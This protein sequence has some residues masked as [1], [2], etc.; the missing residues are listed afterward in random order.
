MSFFFVVMSALVVFELSYLHIILCCILNVCSLW[1]MILTV[2]CI[3]SIKNGVCM[4]VNVCVGGGYMVAHI[5]ICNFD[6]TFATAILHVHA[7]CIQLIISNDIH[8]GHCY[9]AGF[10]L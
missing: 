5:Y 6:H 2:C 7:M 1:N 9:R 3:I 10:P 8:I 4:C